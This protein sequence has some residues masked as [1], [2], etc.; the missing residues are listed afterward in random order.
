M[1]SPLWI[2]VAATLVVATSACTGSAAPSEPAGTEPVETEP[3]ETLT[4]TETPPN[5]TP[6]ESA[7]AQPDDGHGRP[8]TIA[9]TLSGTHT[10]SDGGYTSSGAARFC[11][12][13]VYNLTGNLRAFNFEFPVE[14]E[15]EIIDITVGAADLTPGT[16]TPLFSVNTSVHA[17]LGG[18]PPAYVLHPDLPGS[19]DKGTAQRSDS[20][21]TTSLVVKGTN[22][23][24]E[25]I[26]L[27]VTCGP[28][29]G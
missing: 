27:N 22:D 21:G 13:A 29:A 5:T 25:S 12:N 3:A 8:A 26:D 28:R 6:T 14:G 24:G 20:G 2:A 15:H 9:M 1:R 19:A 7:D 23:F 16:Q 18:T 17:K 11:G 4:P 10:D